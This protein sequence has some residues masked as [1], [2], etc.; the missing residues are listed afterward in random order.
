MPP[1]VHM[2]RSPLYPSLSSTR[3]GPRTL[4]TEKSLRAAAA[5]L[6]PLGR[7]LGRERGKLVRAGGTGRQGTACSSSDEE[8]DEEFDSDD[9][10]GVHGEV[11]EALDW[12]D[13]REGTA[14]P[15]L[16]ST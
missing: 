15:I 9:E 16:P 1:R 14:L 3:A 7:T 11:E 4:P 8:D 12:L 10:A 13:L 2:S 6:V 5:P